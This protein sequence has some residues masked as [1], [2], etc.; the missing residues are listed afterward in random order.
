MEYG[1]IVNSYVIPQGNDV[2]L[3]EL[4]NVYTIQKVPDSNLIFLSGKK[5]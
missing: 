5:K 3:D 2:T 4:W 1:K